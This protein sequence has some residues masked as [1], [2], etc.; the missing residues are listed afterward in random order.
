MSLLSISAILCLGNTHFTH[1]HTTHACA[2]ATHMEIN[3]HLHIF[4]F[5]GTFIGIMPYRAPYPDPN[6]PN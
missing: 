6:H 2:K 3:A 4:V 5:V 1:A